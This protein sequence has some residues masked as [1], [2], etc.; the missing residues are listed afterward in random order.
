MSENKTIELELKAQAEQASKALDKL[1]GKLDSMDENLVKIKKN[2]SNVFNFTSIK[3]FVNTIGAAFTKAEKSASDFSEQLN[4]F[5]VV[6][7]NNERNG[8][9]MYSKLGR[10]ATKFQN[11]LNESFGTNK[12]ETLYMQGIYQS[13]AQNSGITS[14]V[15]A[16]LSENTTKLA[17]DLGSLYNKDE[18]AVA[19]ALRAGI[20][21][22]QTKP[23]TI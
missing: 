2:T 3:N 15:A 10:E 14:E 12:T 23:L 16:I 7:K 17:Y 1:V 11:Q 9:Q 5:N 18:K 19:E 22:G 21:S 8:V 20:Y 6:F 4:L 13:M